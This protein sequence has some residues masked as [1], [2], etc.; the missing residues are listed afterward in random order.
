M[1]DAPAIGQEIELETL[2]FE[3]SNNLY[4]INFLKKDDNIIIKGYNTNRNDDLKYSYKLSEEEI[5]NTTSCISLSKFIDKF[6]EFKEEL[7]IEKTEDSFLL[8]ILLNKSKKEIKTIELE[9]GY[10]EEEELEG[11]INN[12]EDAIKM[13][14]ILLK[15]NKNLKNELRSM[16]NKFKEYKNKMELNFTFNSLDINSY[17][18]NDI[19]KT[20][21]CNDIIQ[22]RDDFCLINM[23]FQNIFKKNIIYIECI[24]KS[25]KKEYDYM[26]LKNMI[27]AHKFLV[28]VILTKN[29]KR[30]GAFIENDI[31]EMNDMNNNNMNIL[32]INNN[33]MNNNLGMNNNNMNNMNN[34]NINNMNNNNMNNNMNY[35]NMNNNNMNNMNN[36][37][38]NMRVNNNN[39]NNNNDMKMINNIYINNRRNNNMNNS[40]NNNNNNIQLN[41][42]MN[43]I[44]MDNNQMN[45]NNINNNQCNG[46]SMMNYN[47]NINSAYI[48][49]TQEEK[50]FSS[51]WCSKDYFIFSLDNMQI[52]FSNNQKNKEL[53]NFSISYD[54]N[55][56]CFYG[57]EFPNSMMLQNINQYKLN[58]KREFNIRDFE[59]YNVEIGKL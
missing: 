37:N 40:N 12:L 34:N 4:Q 5:K 16:K 48:E 46:K 20:I 23:G 33:N 25:I 26:E 36:I 57:L 32:R 7:K 14:K 27:Q 49:S 55:R 6:K 43:N 24:Y 3:D 52:F 38:N 9:E 29:K 56:Q 42:N 58:D 11:G 51:D 21:P 2:F 8:H 45:N 47:N 10:E 15:V 1:R 17:K 19:F 30:F 53:P 50:I 39:M 41:K 18:L 28:I 59:L 35:N 54:L 22:S 31:N 44:Y 13:I